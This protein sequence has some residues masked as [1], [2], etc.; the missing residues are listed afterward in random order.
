VRPTEDG[1]VRHDWTVEEIL[2][3]HETPLLELVGRANAT[4]RRFRPQGAIQ[5]AALISV[6]TGGC[7][8]DCAYCPQSARHHAID[9]TPTRLMNPASVVE[10]AGRALA[11]GA[12][13]FCMG[14]AWRRPPAGGAFDAV[15]EMV[16]GVSALGLETCVTLGEL[17]AEQAY[18]LAG[19][20]LTA[21]NH[22]LDTGPEFYDRIVTTHTHADRLRTLAVARAA[23]LQLCC[24]G[25]VGM[26]ETKRDRAALLRELTALD[27]HPEGV[28]I[29]ALT[30]V[31]G[32]PLGDLRPP[33]PLDMVRMIATARLVLP[34][35][36]VRLSAGRAA[37]GREAQILCFLAGADAV[38]LGDTL[39][40]TPNATADDDEALFA[41]LA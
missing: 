8:E 30:P 34:T 1:A 35:S 12:D 6:K 11:A 9:L 41:A 5:K 28:P 22:N 19:A 32:T 21:Y 40:T 27:P 33:D 7:S 10:A 16:R 17:D 37:M 2:D 15:L 13:R 3:L 26:G 36:F 23:G 39:L 14:A 25:I 24:G 31:P 18:R 38:F 4:H 29:N 20:G